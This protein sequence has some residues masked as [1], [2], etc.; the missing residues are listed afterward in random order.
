MSEQFFDRDFVS[1]G[2][3]MLAQ[4]DGKKLSNKDHAVFLIHFNLKCVNGSKGSEKRNL[5]FLFVYLV[6]SSPKINAIS[7][8]KSLQN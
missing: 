1:N 3:T 8:V 6:S 7:R 4:M 5:L 2:F